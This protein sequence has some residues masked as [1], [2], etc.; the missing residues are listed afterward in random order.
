MEVL[1]RLKEEIIN[2]SPKGA[3]IIDVQFEGPELVIYV[4]NP[5]I[6]TNDIIKQLAKD[7]RKRIVIRPD[8]S[9]LMEPEL[10]KKK[11][12]EIVPEDAGITDIIFDANTGEV[13]IESKKPGLVIGKEGKTLEA[14]KKAI[15]WAPKPV[16]APPIP[17]ETIKAIRATLFRERDEVKEILRRIGRRIHR[18][19]I[20]KGDYWIRVSFL[21]GAREVGR[22]CLLLQTPDTKVLLD[23]G[24]NIAYEEKMYPQFD[25]PEFSIED[26][27]AVIITHAHLDHCGFLPGLFRYGYDGPVY[28]TRPT[29]DLMTLLQKDYL[30]IAEKEGKPVPFSSKEIKECV[31]HVIP[32]DYGVTTDI[33]PSIKLTLHNAGHVLGSA[34]AHLHFG[35]GL[36]NL[37]YTGDLK[38]DTSRLLEP[39][40]CQFPRLEALII[41]STY[42]GY[43]D[44]LPD[45]AEAEKELLRIVIEHIEKGGK[46]LIPVFGVGRAQEL[47]LVLE[48]GYNQGIFNA[49]VYL[50][51]MIWEATAIHTAYPEYLSKDMRRKIFQEGDNPFLSDVFQRVRNTN[52]RRRIIDDSEPCVILATSGM[53]TGGPSLEYFKNLA[54]DE[55]NAIIFVGYQAEGTLG[56]KVQKGWKE[57]PIVTKNGKTKSIPIN[58]GV[59]TV[60]GFSGHSDRKQLIRYV[61]KVKPSPEKIIMVHGE[62][63]KCLD[64]SSTVNRLFKKETYAPRVLDCIRVK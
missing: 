8:P 16:R 39:A 44:V 10:A 15:R 12:L 34:I 7:L 57:I 43:D 2:K 19:V 38:F 47:M 14:I 26:L 59:Y 30:D 58:M 4:K 9:V 5:E 51:G 53:L 52:D 48:E 61:R 17:S 20:Q 29:R 3:K 32:L 33:S 56:R 28:C 13:I 63:S 45:R 36:Y 25:A 64:F 42:G 23:C 40:V 46:I 54:P 35:E 49:P 60:E 55:K 1:E 27:D 31:K 22:S 50:D 24:V 6:Y 37:A 11:I 18:E 62:E 21:G 41:E